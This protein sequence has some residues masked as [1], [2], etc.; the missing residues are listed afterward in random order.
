[1]G[2]SIDLTEIMAPC[3]KTRWCG[4]VK[5]IQ[6][7][8]HTTKMYEDMILEHIKTKGFAVSQAI[9]G[10]IMRAV[11]PGSFN[12]DLYVTALQDI[13]ERGLVRRIIFTPPNGNTGI[14]YFPGG[15]QF[16]ITSGQ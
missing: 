13:T 14:I 3:W 7:G 4:A 1:M 9:V 11:G 16:H 2:M 12:N 6:M 8:Q 5:E 15:T 10:Q